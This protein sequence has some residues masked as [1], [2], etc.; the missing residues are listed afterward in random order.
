M[1]LF[2]A[3]FRGIAFV[4]REAEVPAW[5]AASMEGLFKGAG[6][7]YI[8]RVPKPGGGYRYFYRVTGG[9]GLAHDDEI[10][11]G[12]AFKM[13]HDG[14]EGHFHVVS[15]DGGK[16]TVRHDE[17]GKTETIDKAA[18]RS[19]LHEH[20]AE[21]IRS[22]RERIERERVAADKHGASPKA[23]AK[24]AA[25]LDAH[26]HAFGRKKNSTPP[27]AQPGAEL[28]PSD[29]IPEKGTTFTRH[30]VVEPGEVALVSGKWHVVLTAK[31]ERYS[32]GLSMGYPQDDGVAWRATTRP[33][34]MEEAT[35]A[36]KHRSEL[37]GYRDTRAEL[38]KLHANLPGGERLGRDARVPFGEVLRI[39]GTGGP[40]TGTDY[41]VIADDGIYSVHPVYDDS[42]V[43]AK[44]PASADLAAKL[45]TM[46]E[47]LKNPP[48]ARVMVEVPKSVEAPKEKKRAWAPAPAPPSSSK[49]ATQRDKLASAGLKAEKDG[50]S[51]VLTGNTYHNKEYIKWAGGR[52][53]GEAWKIS[54]AGLEKLK[55]VLKSL[56]PTPG[57]AAAGNY[58][59]QHRRF[60]GLD[61]SIENP[62]GST[63]SGVSPDGKPWSTTMQADYGYI[64]RTRGV[65][66][67]HIDVYLG[68][69]EDAENVFIVHQVDPESGVYDE[70]KVMVGYDSVEDARRAYMAH[71]DSRKFFGDIT[72]M[73]IERF[74][75]RIVATRVGV[76]VVPEAHHRTQVARQRAVVR[77]AA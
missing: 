22:S 24:I 23:K 12:A 59:K 73:P 17:S 76:L 60:A 11:A 70:D 8:R 29:Q 26:E 4:S 46:V 43:V 53:N 56:Q 44:T 62:A 2:K 33:A 47:V 21:A 57:Q 50:R 51:I 10:V 48:L 28:V 72:E 38:T 69:N 6:H 27:T 77:F 30:S 1:S 65:D 39:P 64:K 19:M 32:E 25:E 66:G 37:K 54:P 18:L 58:K 13:T 15:V 34:T 40:I 9:H 71:Y 74:R 5:M 7:K 35:A 41:F 16:V 63:R 3:L 42:P 14:K 67:D 55:G 68:P 52:W 31:K 61:I 75:E 20:H 49:P 45:R 36:A